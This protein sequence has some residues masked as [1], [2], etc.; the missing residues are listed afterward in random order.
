M[1]G[2]E[3]EEARALEGLPGAHLDAGRD[4]TLAP[5]LPAWWKLALGPK[6]GRLARLGS[7][8]AIAPLLAALKKEKNEATRSAMMSSLARFGVPP[9]QV[10][11]RAGLLEESA[12]GLA[13]GIP[14]PLSWFP[15]QRLPPVHWADNGRLVE[16]QIVRWWLAQCCRRKSPEPGPLL[17]HYAAHLKTPG[18][19]ALGQFVLE[20]WIRQDTKPGARPEAG[21]LGGPPQKA[22]RGAARQSRNQSLRKRPKGSAIASKGVLALAGACAAAGAAPL[23][24]RYLEEWYGQRA[25][26]CRALLQMLAWVEH[27]AAAQLLRAVG[28]EFRTRSIQEEASRQAEYLAERK[29][30]AEWKPA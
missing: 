13:E 17:R 28:S 14:E 5:E 1:C 3:G 7:A 18:R 21:S 12:R 6:A 26:Q 4:E 27:P 2:G 10:L 9:E 8:P 19:E 25:A 22:P 24:H 11:D 30:G 16:P 20:T 15:F 23:V 29:G